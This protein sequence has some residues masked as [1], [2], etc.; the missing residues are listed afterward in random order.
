M[1]D[2]HLENV[3]VG[4]H[5]VRVEL[6]GYLDAVEIVTVA[7][8]D[9]A[10]VHFN[11]D[12]AAITLL[13]G[14][15]FVST[16]KRLADGQDT[17]A[18]FDGV[19][20]DGRPILYYNGIDQWKAMSRDEAFQPLDGVWIYAN[21][22]YEI[23]LAFAAASNSLPP[24]KYLDAGWN[25]I[26]FSDTVPETAAN[27]L[28][29]VETTWANLWGWKADEQAYD[30]SIIRGATGRHGEIRELSPFQGY[31]V[32]MNDADTLTAIGA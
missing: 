5:T 11:L 31:W 10:A 24:A 4:A 7:S 19:N 32:Y 6:D 30:I 26:G 3:A 9:I 20:T 18:I 23:P 8:G 1:T 2:A 28:R 15:N 14:W 29:T 22:T 17:I 13:P 16:P 12:A 27:T 25:T 21:G